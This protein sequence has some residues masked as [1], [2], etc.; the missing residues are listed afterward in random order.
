MEE[1]N[2]EVFVPTRRKQP[3][4]PLRQRAQVRIHNE[5]WSGTVHDVSEGGVFFQPL[6]CLT[7]GERI[8]PEDAWMVAP[9]GAVVEV[10]LQGEA[11]AMRGRVT[12]SGCSDSHHC[13]G[14]GVRLDLPYPLAA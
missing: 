14:L 12:W 9:L 7:T 2:A 3:R 10:D 4:T 8:H 6:E 5:I 1:P 13:G 11:S